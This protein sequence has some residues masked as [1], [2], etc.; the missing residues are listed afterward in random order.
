VSM[1]VFFVFLL[2]P[3]SSVFGDVDVVRRK[4]HSELSIV[5]VFATMVLKYSWYY[6]AKKC[7]KILYNFFLGQAS[8]FKPKVTSNKIS[9]QCH[10]YN[11]AHL[12]AIV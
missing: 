2:S 11:F 7:F 4:Q 6:K 12:L 1:V 10:W 8:Y 9:I 3:Q 5:H